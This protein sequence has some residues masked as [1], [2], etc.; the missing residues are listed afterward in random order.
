MIEYKGMKLGEFTSATPVL[1]DPPR[2]AIFWDSSP[3]AKVASDISTGEILAYIPNRAQPVIT[4]RNTWF[5][6]ALLPEPRRATNRELSEW[7]AQ[8]KGQVHCHGAANVHSFFSYQN[9][10]DDT[11]VTND[12]SVRKFG[13]EDWHEPTTEYLGITE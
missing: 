12:I 6:C 3:N 10:D 2:K 11:P 4:K 9:E 5:Y 8:G 13:D 7:C 1:F